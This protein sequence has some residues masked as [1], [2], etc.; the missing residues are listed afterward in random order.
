MTLNNP[1][2]P[3]LGKN[4]K[5]IRL[6]KDIKQE[7]MAQELG[8][9]QNELSVIEQSVEVSNHMLEQCA[10]ILGVSVEIIKNFDETSVFYSINNHVEN[11]TFNDFATAIHQ[12]FSPVDKITDLYERLLK[13][14]KEKIAILQKQQTQ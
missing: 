14:E 12:D 10:L 9:S 8:I 7:A 11:N 13:C 1:S 2:K 5:A 4:I 3:N 6:L